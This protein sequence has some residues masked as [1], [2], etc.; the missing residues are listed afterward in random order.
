MALFVIVS[1][2]NISR[3]NKGEA[4]ARR[5][6]KAAELSN[7]KFR[8]FSPVFVI[9][10]AAISIVVFRFSSEN[11]PVSLLYDTC[12]GRVLDFCHL[13]KT[14]LLHAMELHIQMKHNFFE[15]KLCIFH[16]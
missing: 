8:L 5:E 10:R 12:L 9:S 11:K 13:S 2:S 6:K 4:L 16:I 3:R 1:P 15:T 14:H 7:F